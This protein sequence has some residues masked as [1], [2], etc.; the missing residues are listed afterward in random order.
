MDAAY[1][2]LKNTALLFAFAMLCLGPWSSRA[3]AQSI[4]TCGSVGLTSVSFQVQCLVSS[5]GANITYTSSISVTAGDPSNWV[6]VSPASGTITG[7]QQPLV[8]SLANTAGLSSTTHTAVINLTA[9]AP[10]G[11][12]GGTISV[13]YTPGAGGGG[14]GSTVSASVTSLA[15]CPSGCN[16][17]QTVTLTTSSTSA[18]PFTVGTLP[19][20]LGVYQSGGTS[21][22][23]SSSPATL[24]VY[25][26]NFAT[27]TNGQNLVINYGTSAITIP[28]SVTGGSGGG[29]GVISLSQTNVTLNYVTGGASPLTTVTITD[30][31]GA[32]YW[33]AT[34]VIT[35][36]PNDPAWLTPVGFTTFSGNTASYVVVPAGGVLQQ[37]SNGTHTATITISD[38]PGNNTAQIFVT[39]NVNG[40]ST[41]SGGLTVNPSSITLPQV[42]I[43][44]TNIVQASASVISNVTGT[45]SY[46]LSGTCSGITPTF[47]SQSLTAGVGISL[48][49]SGN[50]SGYSNTSLTD[51]CTLTIGLYTSTLVASASVPITWV[52]GNGS[53]GGSGAS[54]SPVLPTSLTFVSQ[55]GTTTSLVAQAVSITATGAWTATVS[56]T[57][58]GWIT[59]P[60][61][62]GTGPGLA[63]VTITPAG[64]SAGTYTGTIN[65][66]TPAGTQAVTVTLQITNGAP[67]VYANPG[68]FALS[69]FSGSLSGSSTQFQIQASD[70]S[71]IPFTASTSTSWLVAPASG[72][73]P[74]SAESFGVNPAGLAN[75]TYVGSINISAPTAANPTLSIPVVLTVNGSTSSG[76]SLNFSTSALT[77]SAQSGGVAPPSQTLTVTDPTVAAYSVSASGTNNN[78]TWLSI[79]PAGAIANYSQPITVNVNQSGLPNGS[80]VGYI[81]NFSTGPAGHRSHS[82]SAI[83]AAAA[84]SPSPHRLSLLVPIKAERSRRRRL[85]P[86]HPHSVSPA[87]R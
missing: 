19:S 80:Y 9:T 45:L 31:S 27:A 86:S 2:K 75:G 47:S 41:G 60:T 72:T 61:T 74:A 33:Q 65:F 39:L 52:I 85:L 58:S 37:L 83:R 17:T 66:S 48:T 53:G 1:T 78:I 68:S 7:T 73:T 34:P 71:F 15:F 21:G 14:S 46:S 30:N 43:G 79:Q 82:M 32:L 18:I 25:I 42:G 63:A 59:L 4:T 22:I 28:I 3:S 6:S 51:N 23:V 36:T 81:A 26:L 29:T 49:V 16:T 84:R 35:T 13:T 54:S 20:W 5:T 70:G 24:T 67:V 10:A 56:S 77:F 62:S 12:S 44:A 76:G 64:L 87:A 38:Y 69:D 57:P 11:A 50:P 8:V 55:N 40:S